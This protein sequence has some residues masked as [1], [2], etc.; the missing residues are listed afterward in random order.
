MKLLH[1]FLRSVEFWLVLNHRHRRGMGPG[2]SM[3]VMPRPSSS[4]PARRSIGGTTIARQFCPSAGFGTRSPSAIETRR[5]GISPGASRRDGVR[6]RVSASPP[7]VNQSVALPAHLPY[8]SPPA[9]PVRVIPSWRDRVGDR[10]TPW[11]IAARAGDKPGLGC[12]AGRPSYSQ[13]P[14]EAVRVGQLGC[15]SVF[16]AVFGFE[17]QSRD[18]PL[19]FGPGSH[20]C[21]SGTIRGG[22]VVADG[23]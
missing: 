8:P 5:L 15:R 1:R 21:T 4:S 13:N 20:G 14:A 7:S 9:G 3:I 18:L 12:L 17:G 6:F 2:G 23:A 11:R 22:K 10:R 16:A 19:A